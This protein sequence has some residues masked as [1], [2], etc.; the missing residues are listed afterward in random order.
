VPD[1]LA[2]GGDVWGKKVK[3]GFVNWYKGKRREV[4]G[5]AVKKIS[6]YL[7]NSKMTDRFLPLP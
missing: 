6:G 3:A 4:F 7:L 2:N 1:T 5:L